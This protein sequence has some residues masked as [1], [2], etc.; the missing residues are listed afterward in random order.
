MHPHQGEAEP[1]RLETPPRKRGQQP[2]PI[3]DNPHP[4]GQEQPQNHHAITQHQPKPP[5]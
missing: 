1:L 3:K 2:T 5:T 4:T